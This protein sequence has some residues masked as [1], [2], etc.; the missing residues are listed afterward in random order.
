VTTTTTISFGYKSDAGRKRD[1]NEDSCAVLNHQQLNGRLE[2]LMIVGD[3][4]GGRRAGEVASSLLV[5]TISLG[6]LETT[7]SRVRPLNSTDIEQL[8]LDTIVRA[9]GKIMTQGRFNQR[10]DARGM[11]TTCVAAIVNENMV[12]IGNVGDSRIYLLRSGGIEQLT[13]DHSEVYKEFVKGNITEAEARNHRFRNQITRAVGLEPNVNPD[14]SSVPLIDGD[15]LMLCSDGLTT[16]VP[17]DVICSIL[18]AAPTAQDA[19]DLLVSVALRHGGRDNV[20]VVVMRY[21]DFTPTGA[22]DKEYYSR[23]EADTDP[24]QE[25]RK[26]VHVEDDLR[27]PE[28]DREPAT[29]QP[30]F[31]TAANDHTVTRRPG[32][33]NSIGLQIAFAAIGLLILAALVEGA[34]IYNLH[35]QLRSVAIPPVPP[36]IKVVHAVPGDYNAP[37]LVMETRIRPDILQI[38]AKGNPIIA[39]LDGQLQTFLMREKKLLPLDPLIPRLPET[40]HSTGHV[41]QIKSQADLYCDASG[42]IFYLDPK[43]KCI[44]TYAATGTRTNHDLGKGALTAPTKLVVDANDTI[45]IIDDG[46]L[47]KLTVKEEPKAAAHPLDADY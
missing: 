17:D 45:F 34:L 13:Q 33:P 36:P 40:P 19:S 30:E 1:I 6:V 8:L 2:A 10:S 11:A 4:L 28:D 22:I 35:H 38:S 24:N 15:T 9:N 20:T 5:E 31:E 29:D 3:G 43:T 39:T 47:K 23:D 14:I 21:G 25:W 37:S 26:E 12:T 44:E 46:R 32:S 16:E 41:M 27:W 7:A 18:A 42:N